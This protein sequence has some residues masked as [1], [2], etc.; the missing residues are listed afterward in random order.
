MKLM[1]STV[2]KI[3]SPGKIVSH[4]LVDMVLCE[5]CNMLPGGSRR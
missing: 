3:A 1:Q 2:I 5:S 4:G